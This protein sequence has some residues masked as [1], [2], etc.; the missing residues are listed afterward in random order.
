MSVRVHRRP[1][2]QPAPPMPHGEVQLQ[3]PPNLPGSGGSQSTMQM[4]FMLPMMLGM[5]VMSFFYIGRTSGPM[6]IIFGVLY[7]GMMVGMLV[8]MLARGGSSKKAEINRERRDYL[9][10]LANLRQDVRETA[11]RQRA[12]LL[13][14]NPEPDALTTTIAGPRLWERRRSDADALHMRVGRGPQRLATPLKSPQT[15][16]LED[17][18][19]VASTSLRHFVRTYATVPDLPVAVATRSFS[20]IVVAGDRVIS[21]SMARSWLA[22]LAAFHSPDDLRI[23]VLCSPD[24]TPDWEWV[25]WLPHVQHPTRNTLSGPRNQVATSVGELEELLAP[26]LGER[27]RY[28]RDPSVGF[29]QPHIVV[30]LDDPGARFGGQLIVEGGLHGVTVVDLNE[31][32]PPSGRELRLVVEAERLGVV[33]EA[34]IEY[35]GVP[36]QLDETTAQTLARQMSPIQVPRIQRGESALTSNVGLPELLGI[37]DPRALDTEVTWRPRSARERLRIP[38]GLDPDGLPVELDLK[39]SAEGGMG[40]HGLIIGATGSGK[41]ELLRTLVTGLAAT[42]SSATLNFA[43]VDFKG[44][45]TFAGLA[46]LPHT[47]AVITNLEDD[48]ALV[49]RMR[50]AL[51]GELIRRQEL[52]KAAGN[53]AS[54]RDYERAREAGANLVPMATLLVIIDE[55]S[56]LLSSKPDFIEI[57]VMIGR[58]GRSL[59]VHLLLASQRLDEGRLRG[60]DS[61]LS[62]RIGLRTFSASESRSVLGVPDAYELPSV[63]G[64]AYLKADTSS[65]VR[66]KAAFVS[67]MLPPESGGASKA[68]IASG[69][70]VVSFAA[71]S[72]GPELDEAGAGEEVQVEQGT[73]ETA[74]LGESMLEAM[75]R[76]LEG[77]GPPPHQVWLPPLGDSPSL[78]RLL[79]PLVTDPDRGLSPVGWAGT[80]GLVI[81]YGV[82][83]KPFEQVRDV[84]WANLSGAAGNAIVVGAPQSGKSTALRTLVSSL[85][86]THTPAE[87]QVYCLDFGGGTLATLAD[88]PHVG[89]VADRQDEERCRRIVATVTRLLADRENRFRA[90]GIDSM[91]TFRRRYAG[92]GDEQGYGDVF[93]VIDNWLTLRQDFE[94]LEE[95]IA[96]L[97]NRGLGYGI[98]LIVSANRWWDVRMQIRDMFGTRLELRLGDPGDS[99]IDRRSASNVPAGAPG[100]GLT[101]ERQQCLVAL[102]RIDGSANKEDLY[103]GVEQLV[104]AVAA[105][106]TTEAPPLGLLP[107]RFELSELRGDGPPL[108]LPIG[109]GEAGLEPISLDFAADPHFVVF[110]DV[111]CGKTNLLRVLVRQLA[112]RTTPEEVRI[113]VADYRRNLIDLADLDHVIGYAGSEAMFSDAIAEAVTSLRRRLPGPEVTA[114]E[115]RNR[116]WWQGPRLFVVVDDYDLVAA[117]ATNPLLPL[118]ELLGQARDVDLHLVVTR[119]AGG[120][121]RAM[122]DPVLGRLRELSSPGLVMAGTRDEGALVGEV[123]P[124]PQPAGRGWLVRRREGNELV[125]IAWAEAP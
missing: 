4:M 18:D 45:A 66:F 49:D 51:H 89:G 31:V 13:F 57:F 109:L 26:A 23:A 105:A 67:G 121:G 117:A 24:R 46:T 10:Y 9:R 113:I 123:K 22:N 2:R 7:A 12:H 62:Y 93:L 99:E 53:Y 120:A 39:E 78:D 54:A 87:V 86:L 38:L 85:A 79:P 76:R 48:L 30:V 61:H 102:P 64:S 116:T 63:P 74:A 55:F 81:P 88:L 111:E 21:L 92:R 119:R 80:G 101:M 14:A 91:E 104:T 72:S 50:E 44:G 100:R 97:A 68:P 125:Q 47:C 118:V 5:G 70:R 1:P 82:V 35:V 96:M 112:A 108:S 42:H 77:Q 69:H 27:P 36:D 124:G 60:L 32:L 71:V 17:L 41:S 52:L 98:H 115:L 25:K 37:G 83:D 29:D 15:V 75:V 122:F 11:L 114:E 73:F 107:R 8:M 43:L 95:Q 84:L 34:G 106:A 16:P 28:S 110:G 6:T 103:A 3:P 19:P 94:A 56:E 33:G 20:Q 65:M 58:L 40:P 90:E 59:G